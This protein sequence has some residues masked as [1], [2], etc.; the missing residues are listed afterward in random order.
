MNLRYLFW[1]RLPS[2]APKLKKSCSCCGYRIFSIFLV[3]SMLC[4]FHFN[5]VKRT[6][7]AKPHWR[8]EVLIVILLTDLLTKNNH[9]C[10]SLKKF[11]IASSIILACD[12]FSRLHF[13]RKAA[14]VSFG[15]SACTLL[16]TLLLYRRFTS[17]LVSVFRFAI[18]SR[19]P[20]VL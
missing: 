15:S 20:S 19:P 10:S 13:S 4:W 17:V 2:S 18:D 6:S 5:S 1:V 9:P 8:K 16:Y 12:T 3:F 11:S 7:K 14:T